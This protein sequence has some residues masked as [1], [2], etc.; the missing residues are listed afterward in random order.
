MTEQTRKRDQEILRSLIEIR[1]VDLQ[2][3]RGMADAVIASTEGPPEMYV[4][5]SICQSLEEATRI[6]GEAPEVPSEAVVCG[7]VRAIR[8]RLGDGRI[9]V[10]TA[11]RSLDRFSRDLQ[12]EYH[13][14]WA[15]GIIWGDHLE[16]ARGGIFGD[17]TELAADFLVVLEDLERDPRQ[18]APAG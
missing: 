17:L 7:V 18:S 4:D 3:V 11:I 15:D 13:R 1:L 6:L 8:Q 2:E 9:D 10:T 5:L 14:L 16:A 12:E